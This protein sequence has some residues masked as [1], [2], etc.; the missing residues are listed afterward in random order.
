MIGGGFQQVDAVRIV[1]AA[2]LRVFVSDRNERAPAFRYADESWVVD[3]NDCEEL[4]RRA[5]EARE[6]GLAGIFTLTE[7]VE[8]VAEVASGAGLP[9]VAP[10]SARACQDKS[11]S[12]K[13]WVG[14]GVATARAG[15]VEDLEKARALFQELGGRV[16]LKPCTAAGGL[17]ASSARSPAQLESSFASA[18][19]V[20]TRVLVE[21]HLAG[22]HH[23]I[24]GIFDRDGRF[25]SAGISDRTFMS[26]AP[27]ELSVSA[28]TVLSKRDQQRALDLTRDAA[29]ALGIR[30]GP[31]KSDLIRTRDGFR[32]LELA[33][34]LHGPKG[35]L[36]LLPLAF[37]FHPIVAALRVL[38]GKPLRAVDL[39]PRQERAATIIAIPPLPGRKLEAIG[40]LKEASAIPGIQ[41]IRI[42]MKL[43][44]T[45]SEPRSNADIVGHVFAAAPDLQAAR[46]AADQAMKRLELITDRTPRD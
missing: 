33:P 29:L 41:G 42:L 37:G 35:T 8:S 46:Y 43:G 21:E 12:K 26:D 34:R 5:I 32:I 7:L 9:G 2:G 44:T 39:R 13:L 38:I 23:D 20:G 40:G 45:M 25:H 22:T 30:F 14:A 16:F 28:P 36:H 17:G 1:A 24:N 19:S 4:T 3:G 6:R 27:V 15:V 18:A 31:V 11:R 10:D